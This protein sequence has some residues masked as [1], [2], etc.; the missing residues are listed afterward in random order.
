MN[1]ISKETALSLTENG[2]ILVD[3]RTNE[4]YA[5]DALDGAINV[6]VSEFADWIETQSADD[7]II[8]YCSAGK[9]SA[10]AV[11]V[12]WEMGYTNVYCIK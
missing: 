11:A 4:E 1:T 9:R 6:P 5:T 10:A 7:T 3:V 8:V 2:A 12:A